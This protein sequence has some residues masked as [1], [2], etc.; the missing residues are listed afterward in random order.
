MDKQPVSVVTVPTTE[1][2]T[3]GTNA[4]NPSVSIS[5]NAMGHKVFQLSDELHQGTLQSEL[6]ELYKKMRT[7]VKERIDLDENLATVK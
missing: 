6:Q 5:D 4:T 7:P 2:V 3:A 1:P